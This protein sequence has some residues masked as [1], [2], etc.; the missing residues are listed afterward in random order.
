MKI[1]PPRLLNIIYEL[2]KKF[3]VLLI[4][5]EIATGF[6]RTGTMF[7]FHQTKVKPDIVCIGKALTGGILSLSATVSTK[8]IFNAFLG[9]KK[10]IEFMH[11]P[12]YMANPLACS[13][14]NATLTYL[15]KND[16]LKKVKKIER[17]FKINLKRFTKYKFVQDT[18]YIGAI[19]VIEV[20][21]FN[22]TTLNW[23]RNEFIKRGV[24][25]RPLRNVIYFMPPFII[26]KSQLDTIFKATEDIFELW[27]KKKI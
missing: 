4:V 5:D 23:L 16:I 9:N 3:D 8:K 24:W 26:K 7:A 15:I 13:A 20:N 12:T 14:A 22:T 18:R 25:A 10:N 19:G 17:Y 1:Y 11:G 2:K 21:G 27:K 6:G